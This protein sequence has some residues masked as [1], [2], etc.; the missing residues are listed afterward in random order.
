MGQRSAAETII[1]I[2]HAFTRQG[3][4]RQRDLAVEVGVSVP[5]LRK[6]LDELTG[7]NFPLEREEEH[8]DVFWSVPRGWFPSGAVIPFSE[9]PDLVRLLCR[10]PRTRERERLLSTVLRVQPQLQESRAPMMTEAGP[11]SDLVYLAA[12]EDAAAKGR[13]LR[14]RYFSASRGDLDWRH[15]SVLRIVIGPPARFV[16]VCHRTDT[17]KWFRLS[18]V[19]EACD[20]EAISFGGREEAAILRFV[21]ESSDGFRDRTDSIDCAFLV[22]QPESRWL[23]RNLLP[24]MAAA[25]VA[26]GIRVTTKTSGV[27]RV[28]RFVVG[29]GSAATVETPELQRLVEELAKGALD[30]KSTGTGVQ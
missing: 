20:D 29:L 17:L 26:G 24:G 13:A 23:S 28:A 27:L 6:R 25:E 5:A 19:V 1:A 15:V 11:D 9:L 10:L 7:H 16:A 22:R 14:M 30:R 4:W 8:P 2:L 3:T 18:N 21:Q 12:V